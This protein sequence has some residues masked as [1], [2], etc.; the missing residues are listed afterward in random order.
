M[1]TEITNHRVKMLALEKHYKKQRRWGSRSKTEIC[2]TSESR[3]NF[4]KFNLLSI[5]K[6]TLNG[7]V[8]YQF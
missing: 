2:C 5:G 7:I 4:N 8:S 1:I 6:K 3:I